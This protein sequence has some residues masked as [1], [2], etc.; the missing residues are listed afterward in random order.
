MTDHDIDPQD[1]AEQFDEDVTNADPDN[2]EQPLL[3]LA[4][5][6]PLAVDEALVSEPIVDSV[7]S[8]EQRLQPEPF[9][10]TGGPSAEMS[11]RAVPDGDLSDVGDLAGD[12]SDLS[13]EEAALHVIDDSNLG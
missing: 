11:G 1:I 13:P 12:P 9:E 4:N 3:G 5:D 6:E 2:P 8:R 7:A 10:E